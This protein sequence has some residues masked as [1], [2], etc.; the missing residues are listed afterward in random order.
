MMTSI[1]DVYGGGINCDGVVTTEAGFFI[2]VQIDEQ[3]NFEE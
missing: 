1:G 3:E 2:I